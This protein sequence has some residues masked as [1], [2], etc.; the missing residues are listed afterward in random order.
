MS[1]TSNKAS[2][3]EFLSV[4][5]G[6]KEVGL[7][8]AQND[9]EISS[10]AK[11]MDRFDFKRSENIA[12]LFKSPKTY[13][14]AGGNLDKNVYDFIVQY[15][16]GQV[17]IFDKKLMQS[18]TLSPDYKNSAIVL[19]VDKDNLNKIQERG[20]DLLSSTGPAFQS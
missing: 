1:N 18:Q 12:D 14:V 16:T 3:E 17:E 10:F 19:L 7:V 2:I 13:L 5:L 8:I 4:I 6:G 11:A 20:F 9:A 15:P